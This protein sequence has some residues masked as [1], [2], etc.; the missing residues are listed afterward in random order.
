VKSTYEQYQLTGY[1]T[2]NRKQKSK[3]YQA[4]KEF[5]DEFNRW[6]SSLKKLKAARSS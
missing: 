5:L 4:R 3:G 2:A 1:F 6:L